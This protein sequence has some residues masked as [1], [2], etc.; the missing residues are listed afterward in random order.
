MFTCKVCLVHSKYSKNN[1]SDYNLNL[2][3]ER[4]SEQLVWMGEGGSKGE[5]KNV[6]GCENWSR[7][8]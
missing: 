5:N 2:K 7:C 6:T 3:H 8:G 1:S 4:R